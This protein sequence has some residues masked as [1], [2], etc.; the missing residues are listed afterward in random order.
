M[1]EG[2]DA[3]SKNASLL[4]G[5]ALS[6]Y[7][8][9]LSFAREDQIIKDYERMLEEPVALATRKGHVIGLVFGFSQFV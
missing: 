6:N 9:V 8:T 3:A 4:A 5:D 7:K 1:T 2:S